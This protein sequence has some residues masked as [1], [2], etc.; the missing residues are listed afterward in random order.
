MTPWPT[1]QSN[2]Q[3]PTAV[4]LEGAFVIGFACIGLMVYLVV[5]GLYRERVEARERE[6]LAREMKGEGGAS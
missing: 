4:A 6:R 2:Q 1:L 5:Y 3:F